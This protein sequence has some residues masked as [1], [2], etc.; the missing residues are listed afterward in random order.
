MKKTNKSHKAAKVEIKK[1]QISCLLS[2]RPINL[3]E[4][5]W[6][7]LFYP[8]FILNG[9]G[10]LAGV[11]VRM[12]Y[13]PVVAGGYICIQRLDIR[14][15]AIVYAARLIWM[16]IRRSPGPTRLP[17]DGGILDPDR[18]EFMAIA[19]GKEELLFYPT[20]PFTFDCA[21]ELTVW[22]WISIFRQLEIWKQ[23]ERFPDLYW[24]LFEKR[25]NAF[26]RWHARK[27]KKQIDF[28]Q[29][30][31][32]TESLISSDLIQWKEELGRGIPIG[33]LS[34]PNYAFN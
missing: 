19:Y 28:D 12:Y 24:T 3:G 34:P 18:W 6:R 27:Y 7:W 10:L 14:I 26:L 16:K 30:N 31:D 8:A 1:K 15:A 13:E 11:K 20:A 22:F 2:R 33:Q 32:E 29:A 5:L 4:R 23:H 9:E 17:K 25:R 21:I